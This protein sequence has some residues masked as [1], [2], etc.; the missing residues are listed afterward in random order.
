MPDFKVFAAGL[1]ILIVLI[2]AIG[3]GYWVDNSGWYRSLNRP[4]WQPPDFVFGLIWPYNF[5]MLGIASVS[6]ANNL[7]KLKSL[8]FL[9]IFAISVIS[10]LLWS[11]FFY[12]PHDFT[13]ASAALATTAILTLPLLALTFQASKTVGILLIPYQVWVTLASFLSASYGRLN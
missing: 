1:G 2:Y 5:V 7:S 9:I 4:S 13:K 6:V 10:A 12:Q 3:S 11:Y 8:S